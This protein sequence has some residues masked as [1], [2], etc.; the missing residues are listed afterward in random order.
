[1]MTF[2]AG[3]RVGD[4][5]VLG[6][7]GTGGMGQVYR[8][9]NLI[10]DRV[11]AMKVLLPDL[12][13]ESELANRFIGEI[14]TLASFD[15]P[16][17]AQLHTAFQAD[18]RLVMIM[19][20][21]EGFTL[22]QRAKQSPI[23]LDEVLDYMTQALSALSY[24]HSRGVI[25]RD[26]KPGN[27]MV[28]P[29]GVLKLMDFGIAKSAADPHLT[30]P[31][32]TMGSLYY[33]SPEQVRGTTID[34][35]SDI[36][37]V[38]VSLYELTAGKRPFDADSTF[39]ILNH[40]LNTAPQP[41]KEL[42]PSL[43][44]ALN[45]IILTS[46]A[47]E[48][49]QR[50]QSAEAFRNALQSVRSGLA[51]SQ[52]PT[53]TAAA[54]NP[55]HDAQPDLQPARGHRALWMTLGAL[56]VVAMLAVAAIVMPHWSQTRASAEP[57]AQRDR[58]ANTTAATPPSSAS[59]GIPQDNSGPALEPPL[60]EQ[61]L[62]SQTAPAIPQPHDAHAVEPPSVQDSPPQTSST[63]APGA[64]KPPVQAKP[65]QTLPMQ[66][67][68]ASGEELEALNNRM[69]QLGARANVAR[70]GIE[71]LRRQ[72]AANGFGLRQ[73]ISASLSRMEAYMDAAERSVQSENPPTA[74]KN[75]DQ[76]EKEID[77]LET[78]LGR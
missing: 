67:P 34:A 75:M 70:A 39:G 48:P 40:Q 32:T 71:Q 31:G 37:S 36:Y 20:Y 22:D 77:N 41:P 78:F 27:M 55:A 68:Q 64:P 6:V 56:A 19:E 50:F 28:T 2:E 76:A 26:I 14:R 21:I 61:A 74:R 57:Q 17:I 46:L 8:V 69:I 11:E 9:R 33:M 24:A 12:S 25:H 10:S 4:Y 54:R 1:M 18:N 52:A 58:Q 73:D 7:L 65:V 23:P 5:E 62:P 42:N 15:H 38:G 60:A 66:A 13:A 45:E 30:R 3:Q 63:P 44:A 29:H 35:R 43:P 72:Q 53:E 59:A 49:M 47:K 16:N 51:L